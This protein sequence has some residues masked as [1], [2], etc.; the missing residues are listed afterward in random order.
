MVVNLW[1]P[2]YNFIYKILSQSRRT[3]GPGFEVIPSI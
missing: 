1:Q 2:Q 3:D